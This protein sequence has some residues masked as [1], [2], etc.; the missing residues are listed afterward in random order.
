MRARTTFAAAVALTIAGLAIGG[1]ALSPSLQP[2]KASAKSLSW[3]VPGEALVRF[4]AGVSASQVAA[5]NA[6]VG[7]VVLRSFQIVPGLVHVR[8]PDGLSVSD[9][10]ARYEAS[11]A[12][13]YAQPNFIYRISKTPNDPL[14]PSMYNLNNTGQTGG[15][16]DADIDAP[17]AWDLVTGSNNIAVGDIDTG[18]D[19]N[20]VDLAAHAK[21][22]PAECNGQ[23]G[24]DDDHNGYVDDCHGID[25]F[26]HDTNPIDDNSHGT[27][28]AGTIGAIGNNG[29]G[30]V[31]VNWDVTIVACKSHASNGNGTA[32]SIIECM[33]YMEIEKAHGLNVV[34]TNNSYGG[35]NEACGYD[36]ATYD[37]IKSNMTKGI[38]FVA[39][40]GNDNSNND[41]VPKYPAT[42][43]IP[44]V[45]SVAATDHTDNRAGFS[46]YGNRTV[47]VGAPGVS[48][49]STIPN[50]SY[51]NF[52]GTSMAGPHVAGLAG[53]LAAQDP[54]R[55]W[56]QIRNLI[57]A[58]G[59]KKSSM[60]GKTI[61]GRRINAFGS[62]SCSGKSFYGVLRPLAT[63]AGKPIPIA[64]LRIKC[65]K[66]KGK[67]I[68]VKIT[69][70]N[71]VVTLVDDGTGADLAAKDGIFS[72]A[73]APNPCVPGTYTFSFKKGPTVQ[74]NITC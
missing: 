66:P 38:L 12:V 56:W 43:F 49:K 39:S 32:A 47:W 50:N 51:A 55:K 63:Q 4:R 30:V 3:T 34:A 24:V 19:Y 20:H 1:A 36:Q 8:L 5:V 11:S 46:N 42:Y 33:Q 9:A 45:I 72:G 15:T 53:L 60:D 26:N 22:N 52:S 74:S 69:P 37:A 40:A 25:T 28:T 21:P 7:A 62:A 29:V 58:G 67:T 41:A 17:E 18:I 6:S 27:H 44:N 59:D 16:P 48:V 73:W 2:A 23:A 71:I 35:C 64:A 54:T 13:A 10:V 68:P 61:T 70:G 57:A 31:G 65:D 14:Y